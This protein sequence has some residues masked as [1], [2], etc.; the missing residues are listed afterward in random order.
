M[1]YFLDIYQYSNL[2]SCIGTNIA[3]RHKPECGDYNFLRYWFSIISVLM[4]WF[5]QRIGPRGTRN[6]K[7]LLWAI[8]LL[9]KIGI[10]IPL[11]SK[12]G[13]PVHSNFNLIFVYSYKYFII[14]IINSICIIQVKKKNNNICQLSWTQSVKL[15]C[16]HFLQSDLLKINLISHPAKNRNLS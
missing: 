15:L 11:L 2:C 13:K 8:D 3:D 4:I 7:T 12:F 5:P 14:L 16:F 9:Y 6:R 10:I 1:H